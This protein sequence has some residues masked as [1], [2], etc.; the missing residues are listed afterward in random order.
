MKCFVIS[1]IGQP[2]SETRKEADRVFGRLIQPAMAQCGIEA[3]RS[4]HMHTPGKISEQMIKGILQSQLCVAVLTGHN[5]NVFFELAVAQTTARP[6]I[7]LLRDGELI[8][9]DVKDDRCISYGKDNRHNKKTVEAIVKQV[10]EL[11]NM[12]WTIASLVGDYLRQ[13]RLSEVAPTGNLAA[14]SVAYDLFISSPMSSVDSL[15]FTEY[16]KVTIE[17]IRLMKDSGRFQ[18]VYYAGE[19]YD[20]PEIFDPENVAFKQDLGRLSN[21]RRFMMIFPAPLVSSTLVEAGYALALGIPSHYFV[22]RK[23]DLPFMLRRAS[24]ADKNVN[25]YEFNNSERLKLLIERFVK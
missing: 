6:V 4:D 19:H 9:F 16:R 22:R 3:F 1:P 24:E 5:P 20:S 2:N 15:S 23:D 17:C 8:P 14:G 12:N 10:E 7:S 11:R 18:E 21:S 13:V 25:I